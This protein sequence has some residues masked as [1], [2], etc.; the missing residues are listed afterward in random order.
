MMLFAA[1]G[2][3]FG[4]S[5]GVRLGYGHR[6]LADGLDAEWMAKRLECAYHELGTVVTPSAGHRFKIEPVRR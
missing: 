6:R 2:V 1:P 4:E 5:R 3:A